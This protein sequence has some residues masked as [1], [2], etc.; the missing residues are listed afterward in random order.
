MD[1]SIHSTACVVSTV[2]R[3]E[4]LIGGG[5]ASLDVTTWLNAGEIAAE[6]SRTAATLAIME[7]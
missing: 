7:V 5:G 1:G 6:T 4:G 3:L 2:K